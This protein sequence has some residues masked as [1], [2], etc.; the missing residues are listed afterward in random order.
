MLRFNTEIKSL[1]ISSAGEGRG[2]MLHAGLAP[3]WRGTNTSVWPRDIVLFAALRIRA[4]LRLA[5]MRDAPQ[6][7]V[8]QRLAVQALKLVR[9]DLRLPRLAY[10]LGQKAARIEMWHGSSDA[11]PG[12][13]EQIPFEYF[14]LW[15]E[16]D[17]SGL[18]SF[19]TLSRLGL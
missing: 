12:Y 2:C 19:F 14:S 9:P 7:A 13:L 8:M 5:Q 3:F 6:T 17:G 4:N 16:R 18:R 10:L 15:D 1:A 11:E